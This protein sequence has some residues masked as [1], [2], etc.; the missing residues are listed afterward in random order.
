MEIP[1]SYEITEK[2]LKDL[3][4]LINIKKAESESKLFKALSKPIRINILRLLDSKDLCVCVLVKLL[5][6]DYSKISYH[7]K[8]LRNKELIEKTREGNFLIYKITFKGKKILK[9]T[10]KI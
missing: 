2:E 9:L 8:T 3:R 6:Y 5:D 1:E 7:L 10:N 4:E